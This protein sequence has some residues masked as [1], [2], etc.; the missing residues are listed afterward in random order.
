[1]S[2]I[3][4]QIKNINF[5]HLYFSQIKLTQ[6]EAYK[7]SFA[8]YTSYDV[9]ENTF[10]DKECE[11][12][13]I[14]IDK[15]D[16]HNFKILNEIV[17]NNSSKNITIFA[18][19]YKNSVLLKFALHFYL[20]KIYQ[21]VDD[22]EEIDKTIQIAINREKE[23]NSEEKST[24]L[25]KQID[26]FFSFLVFTKDTLTFAN[27]KAKELFGSNDLS[28]IENTIKSN[29]EM[30]SLISSSVE[31]NIDVIIK[32]SEN[33]K[34]NYNFYLNL[35]EDSEDK[36][37]SILPH[38]K[39]EKEK[40]FSLTKN[41]YQFIE[42][43][44]DKLA[45][46]S[47]SQTDTSLMFINITNL[48]KLV[49]SSGNAR[50]HEF[51]EKFIEQ[52]AS[53]KDSY[54]ELAQWD[55]HFF[56]FLVEQSDFLSVKVNLDGIHQKLIYNE[57]DSNV[58]P[59]IVSSALNLKSLE[60]NDIMDCIEQISGHTLNSSD[61]N[62]SDFFEINHLNEYLEESEQIA[63]YLRGC[64]NNK[65]TI[66]LLNIYKGLCINTNS[67]VL[68]TDGDS[69]F[70]H[71]ENLQGYS[72]QFEN[73][74]VIQAPDIP[75]DIQ[76]DITYVNIEKSYAV[77]DNLAFLNSSAN[78][79]QHTR[80]QPRSRTPISIKYGKYSYQGEVSDISTQAVAMTLNH[81]LSNELAGK[82]VELHFK[83]PEESSENG[84]SQM[85]VD[86]T[87]VFVKSIGEIKCI[88]VVNMILDQH[89]DSCLLKYMYARQKELIIELKRATR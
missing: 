86:G 44:K 87:I 59:I 7:D 22:K 36:V 76:A 29:D 61:V 85:M 24:V 4:R 15:L 56:V 2:E 39:V 34:W 25:S 54:Q 10:E 49:K 20:E 72:M 50:V 41:R 65:T 74:T 11:F 6:L 1:M 5:A 12:I 28:T 69:V 82:K 40:A 71:C 81:S 21:L 78:N 30:F 26:S 58:S 53:Y 63:H 64:A 35:F 16:K 17:K 3:I 60:I 62:K 33:K 23:K 80:V 73:K 45:Q 19:D 57:I 46:N 18:K 14:E 88:V 66:K 43:L 67:K 89:Y 83:L 51:T 13:F 79:R 42:L 38:N 27:D 31:K 37:I 68:K 84:F 55:S 52:L 8:T 70:V 9:A 77:L 47:A 48:K 75:K 32:N